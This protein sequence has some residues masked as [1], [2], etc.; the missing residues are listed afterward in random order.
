MLSCLVAGIS[1]WVLAKFHPDIFDIDVSTDS[2]VSIPLTEPAESLSRTPS[3]DPTK[4]GGTAVVKGVRA[5]TSVVPF[6]LGCIL[7]CIRVELFRQITLHDGCTRTGYSVSLPGA[8]RDIVVSRKRAKVPNQFAVAVR[9]SILHFAL[10]FSAIPK[11]QDY[12]TRLPPRRDHSPS[13]P[14]YLK[15]KFAICDTCNDV[16]DGRFPREFVS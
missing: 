5:W 8:D 4:E 9:D 7:M 13:D 16:D 3:N 1:F 14:F 11:G 15:G 12:K 2:Y 10:R 6:V